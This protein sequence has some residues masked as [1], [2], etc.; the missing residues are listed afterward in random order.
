MDIGD[1]VQHFGTGS[2]GTV[3][4]SSYEVETPFQQMCVQWEDDLAPH[5]DSWERRNDLSIIPHA[6]YDFNIT[7]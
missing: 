4:D 1:K 3:I 5:K 2:I 6:A 7:D